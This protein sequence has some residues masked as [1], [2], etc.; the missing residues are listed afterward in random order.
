MSA[1]DGLRDLITDRI[2]EDMSFIDPYLA[3]MSEQEVDEVCDDE[4]EYD[5]KRKKKGVLHLTFGKGGFE[6]AVSVKRLEG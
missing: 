4:G 5:V 2:E 1:A 3:R 6:I